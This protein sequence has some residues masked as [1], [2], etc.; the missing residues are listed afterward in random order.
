VARFDDGEVPS[1]ECGNLANVESF[2]QCDHRGVDSAER[3]VGVAAYQLGYACQVPVAM[4][5]SSNSP[6]GMESRNAASVR[7]VLLTAN[8]LRRV[9][10]LESAV[11]YIGCGVLSERSRIAT[12]G[13]VS[14]SVLTWSGSTSH[15]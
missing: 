14:S 5:T 13:P 8:T 11:Q 6:A 10:L 2:G 7:G 4:P 15:E 1:I 12:S 9:P 3:E